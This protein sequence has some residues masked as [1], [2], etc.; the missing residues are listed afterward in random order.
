MGIMT[1]AK[2]HAIACAEVG[3]CISVGTGNSVG[4]DLKSAS[5]WWKVPVGWRWKQRDDVGTGQI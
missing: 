3:D 1:K 2:V 5:E 4:E